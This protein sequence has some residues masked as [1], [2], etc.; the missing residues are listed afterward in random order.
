MSKH[1]IS[2]I[3]LAGLTLIA[4][5][6]PLPAAAD[7]ANARQMLQDSSTALA[8]NPND[9]AAYVRRGVA[10]LVLAIR[11]FEAALRLR[12]DDFFAHHNYAHAA[13]LAGRPQVAVQEFTRALAL[14]PNAARSYMGRGWSWLMLGQDSRAQADFNQALQLDRSLQAQLA[15]TANDIR[16]SRAQHPTVQARHDAQSDAAAQAMALGMMQRM[17]AGGGGFMGLGG[18]GSS[19][20]SH[21]APSCQYS[22]YAACNAARNGDLWAADRIENHT[23]S[24]SEHDWYNE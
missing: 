18:G 1:R 19:G 3:A 5:A 24:G 16:R 22:S 14:N 15:S 7:V 6:R 13:F 8:R 4:V 23:E 20:G 2:S 17:F 9:E 12:P 11:D 21:A 10:H